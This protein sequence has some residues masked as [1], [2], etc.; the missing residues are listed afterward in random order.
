MLWKSITMHAVLIVGVVTAAAGRADAQSV[1][2][3][4]AVGVAPGEVAEV[5]WEWPGPQQS[6]GVPVFGPGDSV[7]FEIV[8]TNTGDATCGQSFTV[9]AEA[10]EGVNT[11]SVSA[12]GG[13]FIVDG[14]VAGLLVGCLIAAPRIAFQVLA[15]FP[16]ANSMSSAAWAR[17]LQRSVVSSVASSSS[18]TLTIIGNHLKA[19]GSPAGNGNSSTGLVPAGDGEELEVFWYPANANGQSPRIPRG[20][21]VMFRIRVTNPGIVDCRESIDVSVPANTGLNAVRVGKQGDMLFVSGV[22]VRTLGPCFGAA[23]RI[24][25]DLQSF[26]FEDPVGFVF[27]RVLITSYSVSGAGEDTAAA[28]GIDL[29][30]KVLVY[31]QDR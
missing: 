21:D 6:E 29:P 1:L 30:Q 13:D 4:A 20:S 19:T 9:E 27:D 17:A 18:G 7:V 22:P 31:E 16:Q 12:V 8:V 14:E 5:H 10:Q 3:I 2:L 23:N 28:V 25:F 24:L 11:L 26:P 15:P